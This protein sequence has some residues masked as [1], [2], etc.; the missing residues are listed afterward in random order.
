MQKGHV[1]TEIKKKACEMVTNIDNPEIFET[2][3]YPF[4]IYEFPFLQSYRHKI[5]KLKLT[6]Q[7]PKE[8]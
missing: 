2:E 4:N 3:H 1:K 5:A 8:N 7:Y 6:E